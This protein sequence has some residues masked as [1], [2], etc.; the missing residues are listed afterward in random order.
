MTLRSTVSDETPPLPEVWLLAGKKWLIWVP[1]TWRTQCDVN[2]VMIGPL[3]TVPAGSTPEAG[4][5]EAT[6]RPE[7]RKRRRQEPVERLTRATTRWTRR[8]A[9]GRKASSSMSSATTNDLAGNCESVETDPNQT[10]TCGWVS[11]SA[12]FRTAPQPLRVKFP[13]TPRTPRIRGCSIVNSATV[14]VL[15]NTDVPH[16]LATIW[17][18][19]RLWGSRGVVRWRVL[20]VAR[21]VVVAVGSPSTGAPSNLQ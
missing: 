13:S 5:V 14:L 10:D 11:G 12:S 16:F 17:S 18:P 4:H 1:V 21:G 7:P 19:A 8:G 9:P 20:E 3:Q 15:L 6:I 2:A